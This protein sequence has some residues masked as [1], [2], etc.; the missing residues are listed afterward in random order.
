MYVCV[1]LGT[2]EC[3]YPGRPEEDSRYLA[4]VIEGHV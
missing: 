2:H 1:W 3:G 4:G